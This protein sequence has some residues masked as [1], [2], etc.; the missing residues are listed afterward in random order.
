MLTEITSQVADAAD[1]QSRRYQTEVVSTADPLHPERGDRRRGEHALDHDVLAG[2]VAG[3][4]CQVSLQRVDVPMMQ[5]RVEPLGAAVG[6][7]SSSSKRI[8]SMPS[9]APRFEGEDHDG[10]HHQQPGPPGHGPSVPWGSDDERA[11]KTVAIA[12]VNGRP[13][14]AA[15]VRTATTGRRFHVLVLR[16]GP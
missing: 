6:E 5:E 10:A 13:V 9:H 11:V 4:G 1:H 7:A 8:A 16:A 12:A 2:F 3:C 14:A 15:R